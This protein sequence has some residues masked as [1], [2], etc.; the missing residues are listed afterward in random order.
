MLVAAQQGADEV[1]VGIHCV[2]RSHG[3][4]GLPAKGGK[5][6]LCDFDAVLLGGAHGGADI[7]LAVKSFSSRWSTEKVSVSAPE[8]SSR[9]AMPNASPL[10]SP[11]GN[12]LWSRRAAVSAGVSDSGKAHSALKESGD[13]VSAL[14]RGG[15]MGLRAVG[16]DGQFVAL[17]HQG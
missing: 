11:K 17:I 2:D 8:A 12:T 9:W 1:G 10:L 6:L 3:A 14:V 4:L 15:G 13:G 5:L 7:K 16:G